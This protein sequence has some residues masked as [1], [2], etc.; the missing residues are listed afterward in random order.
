MIKDDY[1]RWLSGFTSNIGQASNVA[2]EI[3]A[4]FHGLLAKM[5]LNVDARIVVVD[6]PRS[7]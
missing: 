3:W 5:E 2:A 7:L 4:M 1:G 6:H